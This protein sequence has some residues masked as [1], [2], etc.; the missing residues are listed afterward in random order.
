MNVA[1]CKLKL[2][3][4]STTANLGPGFDC[5]GLALDQRN[6]WEISLIEG[7]QPGRCRVT[8]S[9]GG[10]DLEQIPRDENHLFFSSWSQ[11][12]SMG[13]GPDAFQILRKAGLE[14]E[15]RADNCTPIA[16]GLGSSAA[17]RVASAEAYRRITTSYD[18]P[19]WE[20]A[21]QL[22]GHPDNAGPAGLGGLFLGTKDETG[23]YRAIQPEIHPCWE[24]VV[25]VPNF[26]LHTERAR[27]VLPDSLPLQDAIF[28]MGRL[29]FLIEGLRTGDSDFL[30][31]GC[32]DRLH[33]NQRS[34]L[35]PGFHA[36]VSGATEAGA[37]CSFLSG[38]GP[39]IASF[40]DS[41]K[42]E[43]C[44]EQ[45][46]TAMH[47]AFVQSQVSAEV[48]ALSVDKAGLCVTEIGRT[49]A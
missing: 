20:L 6:T 5:V 10:G 12:H 34:S 13:F 45:V 16:R 22:E 40:V 28:N 36:V 30:A 2:S 49:L 11:L 26:A 46:K 38:A 25:A 15:L 47:D 27:Q 8:E 43:A 14:V 23:R 29:P 4:P 31:L 7:S 48:F 41:R 37:A 32:Q 9:S 21:S 39:T 42:G 3:A 19:A 1:P 17:V 24:L 44:L 35:I 33:Q 18:R